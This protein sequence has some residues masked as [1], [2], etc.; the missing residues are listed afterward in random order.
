MQAR[1]SIVTA[2]GKN[3]PL[4][5]STSRL[6]RPQLVL[7]RA[8]TARGSWSH[9][10]STRM[11]HLATRVGRASDQSTLFT[12]STSGRPRR[13]SPWKAG[14]VGTLFEVRREYSGAHRVCLY[15]C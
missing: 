6:R 4:A 8:T 10:P 2:A 13:T 12:R 9:W 7:S 14:A 3:S 1:S 5:A 15:P 11:T